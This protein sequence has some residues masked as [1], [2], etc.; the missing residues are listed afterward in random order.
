MKNMKIKTILAI[1]AIS[2]S[3]NAS[4]KL[5]EIT[6]VSKA[7]YEYARQFKIY[8]LATLEENSTEPSASFNDA[9][10][11]G[12]TASLELVSLSFSNECENKFEISLSHKDLAD[13]ARGRVKKITG[14]MDY[15]QAGYEEEYDEEGLEIIC[16][17]TK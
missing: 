4:F 1:L 2:T 9:G 12:W 14:Q 6:C 11:V 15:Y 8:D 16:Q 13:L 10:L 17:K 5:K 7:K 3:A